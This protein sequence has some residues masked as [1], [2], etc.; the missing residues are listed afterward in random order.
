MAD[1][2]ERIEKGIIIEVEDVKQAESVNRAATGV[3]VRE[4]DLKLIEEVL[5]VVS[6]PVIA[7]C[8]VGHVVEARI[9]EKL[10]VQIIDESIPTAMPQ[11]SKTD[12]SSSFVCCVEDA[13][14]AVQRLKEGARAVRTPIAGVDTVTQ[15][16]LDIKNR[17]A[18]IPVVAALLV[19]T[20]QDVALLLHM[21]CHAVIASSEVFRSGNPPRFMD[22]LVK[23]ARYY[24]DMDRVFEQAKSV[25]QILPT[26]PK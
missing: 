12:F 3:F 21:D 4:F 24:H 23:T 14:S 5:D 19:A 11:V 16:V 26:S 6:V 2:F 10:G 15:L 8:R 7:G 13:S 1:A 22:A 20:P 18:S 25:K 9:L 17:D